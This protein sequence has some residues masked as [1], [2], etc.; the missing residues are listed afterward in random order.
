MVAGDIVGWSNSPGVE[1]CDYGN[2]HGN[3]YLLNRLVFLLLLEYV[4]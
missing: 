3:L 4:R 1:S 2:L